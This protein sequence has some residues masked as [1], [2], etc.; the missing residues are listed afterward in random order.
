VKSRAKLSRG[1]EQS[2]VA[3]SDEV[4]D[5]EARRKPPRDAPGNRRNDMQVL[6]DEIVAACANK[7]TMTTGL[8][9]DG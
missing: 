4:F 3:V 2:E 7:R 5:I 6:C 9:T 8:N 1:L